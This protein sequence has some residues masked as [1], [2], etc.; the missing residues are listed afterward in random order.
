MLRCRAMPRTLPAALATLALLLVAPL[1]LWNL[2]PRIFPARAHDA[3]GALPLALVAIGYLLHRLRARPSPRQTLQASLLAAGFGLWSATQLWPDWP[4]ALVLN[5]LAIGL[6]VSELFLTITA[7]P[8][9]D[10][11][12]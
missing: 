8:A 5:D 7:R 2:L 1:A 9:P 4:H 12:G 11:G 10:L 6:F 3:L